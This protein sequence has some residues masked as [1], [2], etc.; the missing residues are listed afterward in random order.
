MA[1]NVT[2]KAQLGATGV[3]PQVP[4]PPGCIPILLL[5]IVL[6]IDGPVNGTGYS[7]KYGGKDHSSHCGRGGQREINQK[8]TNKVVDEF[9]YVGC[10][11]DSLENS[12]YVPRNDK[13]VEKDGNLIIQSVLGSEKALFE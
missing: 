1:E 2:V 6:T 5:W 9:V 10:G 11:Y 12:L 7:G 3:P 4:P 8:N 13:L